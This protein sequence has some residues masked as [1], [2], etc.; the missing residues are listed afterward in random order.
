MG[1]FLQIAIYSLLGALVGLFVYV[2]VRHIKWKA[3]LARKAKAL[4]E[5]DEPVRSRD[6]WL[7]AADKLEREG[8]Y[9]EAIRALYLASLLAFDEHRVARFERRET[10]W[11]HLRR[12]QISPRL[13]QGLDFLP[14]TQ[15]FDRVWYGH[16]INGSN[17]VKSFR[18]MY[19]TTM[20]QLRSKA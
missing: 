17:D 18:F 1:G 6:E 10:N 16:Q 13:P 19:Q 3:N 4:L 11:E 8:K 15:L 5:D 7:E 12:I 14:A 20:D 2:A 9:R